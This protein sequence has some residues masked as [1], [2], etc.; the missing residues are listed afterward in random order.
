VKHP[1]TYTALNRILLFSFLLFIYAGSIGFGTVWL[2]HQIAMA[3]SENKVIEN[4]I[5]EIERSLSEVDAE[6]AASLS[7]KFLIM[8][9]EELNLRLARPSESQIVRID[10]DLEIRL[11]TK[12]NQGLF[13]SV[14]HSG[15]RRS[16]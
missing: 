4:R 1:P 12:R 8:R 15:Q 14:D 10:D 2:R 9:N 11:A 5:V 6:L 7:P 13:S 16:P 3:A